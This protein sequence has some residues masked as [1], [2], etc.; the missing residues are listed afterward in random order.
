MEYGRPDQ[1]ALK[2][3]DGARNKS[4]DQQTP[5]EEKAGN[6]ADE[7]TEDLEAVERAAA[8]KAFSVLAADMAA[9]E[10][11][12][13]KMVSTEKLQMVEDQLR[14]D[15]QDVWVIEGEEANS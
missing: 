1:G 13:A 14:S 10:K 6:I 12:E 7:G 3:L 8:E 15:F 2:F 9:A 4:G 11:T 5:E